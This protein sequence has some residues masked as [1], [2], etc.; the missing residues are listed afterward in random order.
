M[1]DHS[2]NLVDPVVH[3]PLGNLIKQG[4]FSDQRRMDK[5]FFSGMIE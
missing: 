3:S 5:P 1:L 4:L 2:I